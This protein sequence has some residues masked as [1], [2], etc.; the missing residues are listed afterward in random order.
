MDITLASVPYKS[1]AKRP[2]GMMAWKD[3]V[4]LCCDLVEYYESF[5]VDTSVS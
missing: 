5:P 3:T 2:R 4:V 1:S